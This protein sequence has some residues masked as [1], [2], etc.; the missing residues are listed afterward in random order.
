MPLVNFT[1]FF[2]DTSISVQ[3]KTGMG[4]GVRGGGK[5]HEIKTTAFGGHFLGLIVTGLRGVLLTRY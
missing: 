4:E 1:S 2:S 3:R 5:K